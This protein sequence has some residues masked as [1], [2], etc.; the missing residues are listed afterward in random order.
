M[1]EF[2]EDTHTYVCDGIETPSVT[3]IITQLPQFIDMYK[4]IP[5]SILKRKAEYGDK[6]HEMVEQYAMT[7]EVPDYERKSYEGIAV[8]R[9]MQ[10]AIENDIHGIS[11]E[12]AVAYYDNEIPLYAGKYDLLATVKGEKAIVDIKTTAKYEANYLSHQLTL[13]KLAIE[14]LLKEDINK[15]YCLWLPKKNLGRLIEVQFQEPK[16]LL[17]KV[18]HIYEKTYKR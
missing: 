17:E 3:N 5:K 18:K 12:Q 11:T 6:V 1:I 7:G 9:Y 14:Q 2:F 15:A 8:K 16:G 10:L 13:Y 4:G